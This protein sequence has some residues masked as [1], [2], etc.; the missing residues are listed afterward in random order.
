M[1][2]VYAARNGV[3]CKSE[4]VAA[5]LP[6]DGV[7]IDLIQ[8]TVEEERRV[9]AWIGLE[10]PT[11]EEMQELEASSRLYEEDGATYMTALVVWK[12]DTEE[13]ANTPVT[14]IVS[15]RY[16]ITVRYADPQPFRTFLARRT[17]QPRVVAA[18]DTAFIALLDAIV[19]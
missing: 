17:K 9:E 1:I 7:W 10:I 6:P 4:D 5:G 2:H 19:D 11:R 14:F 13:P 3:L 18:P 8:P 16:L 12:A 15:Q